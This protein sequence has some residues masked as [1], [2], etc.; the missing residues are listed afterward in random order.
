M[1]RR[2]RLVPSADSFRPQTKSQRHSITTSSTLA[3]TN[4][5]RLGLVLSLF[6][7]LA[8]TSKP[9][10]RPASAQTAAATNAAET[11]QPVAPGIEYLQLVRGRKSDSEATG[12]WVINLLRIDL[13]K[14]KLRMVHAMDEAVGLETVSSMATRYGALAAINSSYFRTTGTYRGDSVGVEVL[15]GKLLSEPNNAR[16]AVGL[17][18]SNGTQK[19]ILGH[20]KFKGQIVAGSRA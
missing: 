10:A 16:A 12:P 15:T 5:R 4:R 7:L 14:A 20:L 18:E 9:P 13:S 19:V 3:K 1:M 11:F 6:A 8:I 2:L 17:I